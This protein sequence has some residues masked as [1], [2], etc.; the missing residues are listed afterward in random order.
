[1]QIPRSS[2]PPAV[3]E[4]RPGICIVPQAHQVIL[5]RNQAWKS[6][7]SKAPSSLSPSNSSAVTHPSFP[8]R[9]AFPEIPTPS[10]RHSPT[11]LVSPDP[12]ISPSLHFNFF[13]FFWLLVL[14]LVLRSIIL[15]YL[16][17]LP[18]SCRPL[19]S[20]FLIQLPSPMEPPL[21]T[22]QPSP[23][24]THSTRAHT[25]QTHATHIPD[26]CHI[27]SARAL[28]HT[29]SYDKPHTPNTHTH[30]TQRHAQCSYLLL[31]PS[32]IP[33]SQNLTFHHGYSWRHR[34]SRPLQGWTSLPPPALPPVRFPSRHPHFLS[35]ARHHPLLPGTLKPDTFETPQHCALLCH[36]PRPPPSS[37]ATS[38]TRPRLKRFSRLPPAHAGAG[39]ADREFCVP[40]WPA[41]LLGRLLPPARPGSRPAPP[42]PACRHSAPTS[43][44]V[45]RSPSP[46]RDPAP[47]RGPFFCLWGPRPAAVPGP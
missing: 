29:H 8:L 12:P 25:Y 14:S 22:S 36:H 21:F 9:L 30:I 47:C 7:I 17:V 35:P 33:F 3:M 40:H 20:A 15:C 34:P 44:G 32:P 26:T 1:M 37:L 23:S 5:I 27:P 19:H 45:P 6:L 38:P 46:L 41:A 31:I 11:P 28:T 2:P 24:A 13:F 10:G 42:S 39:G 16:L 43:P 4:I 18:H